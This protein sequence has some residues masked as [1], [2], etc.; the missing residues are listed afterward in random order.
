MN[1]NSSYP[2]DV[3]RTLRKGQ[4]GRDVRRL[5]F[6]VNERYRHFRIEHR[7][8][9]D[10]VL[11]AQTLDGIRQVA[12]GSGATA[13]AR[14][15]LRAGVVSQ[16]IQRLIRKERKKTAQ[17]TKNTVKRQTYRQKL[18][19]RYANGP[20]VITRAE[21]G[22]SPTNLFG[23]LGAP[24]WVTGHYT[25]G[26]KDR[27]DDHA[28]DLNRMYDAQHRRQGWGG[29]GY[30]YCIGRSGTIFCLRDPNQKGAHVGGANSNNIGVMMHGT[31]GDN[32]SEEQA[33]SF[34]WLLQNAHTDKMPASG[35]ASAPLISAKRRGHNDWPGHTS[36]SC[37]GQFKS[38]YL[39]GGSK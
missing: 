27:S 2:S 33:K 18:R 16:S 29:I 39:A 21:Q 24:N 13:A 34:R 8:A 38:M 25:A 31:I 14:A 36:N 1:T 3:R 11:G 32:P 20:R 17:E 12:I 35:R 5:Q 6:A 15:R 7:V 4:K 23:S 10:G 28:I 22:I 9:T 26:P 19:K 37:P 30:H